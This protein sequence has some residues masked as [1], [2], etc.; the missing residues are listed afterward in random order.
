[1]QNEQETNNILFK[2]KIN[3]KQIG[4]WHHKHFQCSDLQV[5]EKLGE[6]DPYGHLHMK[7]IYL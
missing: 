1:M 3:T 5:D 6:K 4:K 2:V 7:G